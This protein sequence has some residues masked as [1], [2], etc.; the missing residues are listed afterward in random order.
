M[1]VHDDTD[2]SLTLLLVLLLLLLTLLALYAR[3]PP[4]SDLPGQYARS[5]SE[6]I[7]K[8]KKAE[9]STIVLYYDHTGPYYVCISVVCC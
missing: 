3:Y 5:T 4:R 8:I 6:I 9:Y 7:L 2:H 1:T